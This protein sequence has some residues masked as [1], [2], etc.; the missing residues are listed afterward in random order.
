MTVFPG[1]GYI[2]G[3][4]L[5]ALRLELDLS[6]GGWDLKGTYIRSGLFILGA[7]L[8]SVAFSGC[9]QK[10]DIITPIER[11]VLTLNP[12]NLPTPPAGL[13]YELWISKESVVDTA[14]DVTQATSLGRF[15]YISSDSVRSFLKADGSP[16][17]AVFDLDGD[18]QSYRSVF[19]GLH[20]SDD[21]AGTK[22]GAIMLIAY[23]PGAL[24][25]PIRMI[26]PQ[27]DSLWQ[28][29]CRFN[30]EA[31]SDNN[32]RLNDAHGLWFSSYRAAAFDIP[33]TTGLTVD[34]T[35]LDTIRIVDSQLLPY[36][37]SVTNI[38][39]ETKRIIFPNDSLLLG[40]DSF[41]HTRILYDQIFR[42]DSTPPH[43]KR[44]LKF[45]F[46]TV[47]HPA[48]LDIFSQDNFGLPVV[49]EWGWKYAG[50]ALT[51]NVAP[52]AKVGGLT[53]PAWPTQ[54]PYSRPWIYSA[55]GGLIPT[56][57]FDNINAPDD[58][59]PFALNNYLPPFPG[60]DF[61]NATALNDSL[62]ISS[63]D[64]RPTARDSLTAVLITME[65]RNRP[66]TNTNTNFPLIAFVGSVPFET[67]TLR[68]SIIRSTVGFNMIN[69]T[70]TLLGNQTYSF[71]IISVDVKRY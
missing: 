37:Y 33:D 70:S 23:I 50:W 8:G 64:L 35:Q 57:T 67:D 52:G 44:R 53:P 13:I 4:Y 16:R 1:K 66:L 65:P 15:S 68:D 47:P 38:R 24:D 39:T 69:S 43:T 56:G 21:A 63:V 49:S 45:N 28:S 46:T 29:T 42:A 48:T 17:D 10:D 12:Q 31:V 30:L 5:P 40:I 3:Y 2:G 7:L 60:E 59:N 55:K 25:I 41:M 20:R 11:S 54:N 58:G 34:S 61:L 27:H 62:G 6:E 19:V 26:F 51:T 18:F 9:S 32:R 14:F 36:I 71:P 22:P